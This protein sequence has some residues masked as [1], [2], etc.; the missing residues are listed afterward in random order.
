LP[1]APTVFNGS[2]N[3][4]GTVTLSASSLGAEI[5]WYVTV[6]AASSFYTGAS[7]TTLEIEESTT[8]YVQARNENTN[9]LSARV[10][11]LATVNMENCCHAPGVTDVTFAEFNPCPATIGSTWTLRDARA[12]GNSYTYIVKKMADGL[13]WMVQD[14]KFGDKC[15]KETFTGS[16]SDQLGNINTS[17]TYYGDCRANKLPNAGYFYDWPAAMNM[18][19]VYSTSSTYQC[20]GTSPGSVY[21]NPGACQGICHPGWHLPSVDEL[22][23]LQ[24]QLS[25]TP[26]CNVSSPYYA[27]S[28]FNAIKSGWYEGGYGGEGQSEHF[29]TSSIESGIQIFVSYYA[30]I[31]NLNRNGGGSL[32]CVLNY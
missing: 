13:I 4:P 16:T 26:G 15:D 31:Q 14:L 6:D 21:P 5:D 17:G 20:I 12:G 3:C 2:R 30:G 22:R 23:T 1:A 8:Y 11:V 9:C 28:C 18:A 25:A 27:S 10:P 7:Y 29:W 24:E 32:R 19:G